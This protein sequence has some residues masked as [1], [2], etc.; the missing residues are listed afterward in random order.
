MARLA[1]GAA[2]GARPARGAAPQ[3]S[4]LPSPPASS[5][6]E[7]LVPAAPSPGPE[8]RAGRAV[9]YPL[10]LPTS[11]P[12][13]CEPLPPLT[14]AAPG[15]ARRWVWAGVRG[16]GSLAESG[17]AGAI[18]RPCPSRRA[19]PAA[20]SLP[21]LNRPRPA[22]PLARQ[23]ESFLPGPPGKWAVELWGRG[24]VPRTLPAG[25]PSGRREEY[26]HSSKMKSALF[27]T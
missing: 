23:G 26:P 14:H 5:G 15:L 7:C 13:R 25:L 19:P 17:R 3:I 22:G 10:L 16:W 24:P 4:V 27:C 2:G 9:S 20:T 12:P 6:R 21:H 11:S 8:G 18:W 1:L